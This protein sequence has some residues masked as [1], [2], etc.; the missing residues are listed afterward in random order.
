MI[1]YK[2]LKHSDNGMPTWDALLGPLLYVANTKD[3]W[4]GRDL[5]NETLENLNM[6]KELL[7]MVYP[8]K[9]HDNI[10]YNQANWA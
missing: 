4:V 1:D 2:Q 6:P 5:I 7:E 3:L 10:S 9:Y 8:S